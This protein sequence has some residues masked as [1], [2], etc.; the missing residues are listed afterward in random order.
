[1]I[2]NVKRSWWVTQGLPEYNVT[3][4]RTNDQFATPMQ[5]KGGHWGQTGL[6]TARKTSG[7][8][9]QLRLGKST[10]L[11]HALYNKFAHRD[12]GV[13]GKSTARLFSAILVFT[14]ICWILDFGGQIENL[15]W[16]G[17]RARVRKETTNFF[18]QKVNLSPKN[19]R[20]NRIGRFTH[21][22]RFFDRFI[23]HKVL[24]QAFPG[25]WFFILGLLPLSESLLI[26]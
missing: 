7:V 20:C 23:R 10:V 8:F 11:M 12:T 1:M 21:V 5:Q 18:G 2:R 24:R 26:L 19:V 15:S 25:G 3:K 4:T 6:L 14:Y 22:H 17:Q 16:C 9:T 13:K